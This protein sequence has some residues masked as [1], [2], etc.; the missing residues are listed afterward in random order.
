MESEKY[1]TILLKSV[2]TF[3][4]FE[5]ANKLSTMP[6]TPKVTRYTTDGMQSA[7]IPSDCIISKFICVLS[8]PFAEV[9]EC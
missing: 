6:E 9:D 8:F 1:W 7:S 4:A 5:R 3:T 2:L